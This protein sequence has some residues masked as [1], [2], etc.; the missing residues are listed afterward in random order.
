LDIPRHVFGWHADGTHPLFVLIE[1]IT[2]LLGTMQSQ[3]MLPFDEDED[4]DLKEK[5]AEEEA[6]ATQRN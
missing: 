6:L 2:S 3:S 1:T 4:T 5:V